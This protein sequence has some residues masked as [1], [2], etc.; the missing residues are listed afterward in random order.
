MENMI[1]RALK[2]IRKYHN[3]TLDQ[4]NERLGYSKSFISEIERGKKN[5]SLEVLKTYSEGFDMP[6]SSILFFA[7]N[8]GEDKRTK[9]LR[10]AIAG[11]AIKLLEWVE[12][13]G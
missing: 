5:P 6:L 1:G 11:K 13:I 10:R 3:L 8:Q 4:L 7:E 9:R 12:D 2:L